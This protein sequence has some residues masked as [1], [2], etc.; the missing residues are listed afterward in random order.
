LTQGTTNAEHILAR[1]EHIAAR[2][3]P[4]KIRLGGTIKS[5]PR[6]R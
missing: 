3:L 4:E 5:E 2:T 6:Q 1:A